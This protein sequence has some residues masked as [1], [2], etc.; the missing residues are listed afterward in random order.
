[1]TLFSRFAAQKL[2]L[3]LRNGQ[4]LSTVHS[5]QLREAFLSAIGR[6]D[7]APLPQTNALERSAR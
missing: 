3:C 5:S 7:P 4:S 1:M 2:S 6:P